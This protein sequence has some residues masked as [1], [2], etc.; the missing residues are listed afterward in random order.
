M[1]RQAIIFWPARQV[2][3]TWKCKWGSLIRVL[4]LTNGAAG[5]TSRTIDYPNDMELQIGVK[6]KPPL[7]QERVEQRGL[8][9]C[10]RRLMPT[11]RRFTSL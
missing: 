5:F 8:L 7:D 1:G 11:K 2:P 6:N 4:V 10:S 9:S 3:A